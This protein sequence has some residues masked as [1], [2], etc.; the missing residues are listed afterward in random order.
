MEQMDR[1]L[2]LKIN[3]GKNREMEANTSETFHVPKLNPLKVMEGRDCL[4][5]E[6]DQ[7]KLFRIT[8]S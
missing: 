5:N 8:K 4:R 7:S 3:Q 2:D 6:L 1:G